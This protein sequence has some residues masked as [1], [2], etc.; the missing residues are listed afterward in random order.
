MFP[1][2]LT[3]FSAAPFL[4]TALGVVGFFIAINARERL[5]RLEWMVQDLERSQRI[6]REAIM[7]G[8]AP[9]ATGTTPPSASTVETAPHPDRESIAPERADVP[10]P[11]P[12]GPPAAEPVSQPVS[13]AAT[14]PAQPTS[15]EERIGTRWVVYVGGLALA[16][17]GLL[18]ARFAIEQGFFGPAMRI[19]TGLALAVALI[20]FGEKLRRRDAATGDAT[21]TPAVLTAAGT[22]TAFGVIYAAHALYGFIGPAF[23]L[24]ALGATALA[25]LLAAL[26]HGPAIAGLGLIGALGAPLLVHSSH[27]NPWPLAIYLAIVVG[28]AYALARLR[29]WGWLAIS[30]TVGAALWG[31]V[32]GIGYPQVHAAAQ[33]HFAFHTALAAW[34]YAL[35]RRALFA[36][37]DLCRKIANLVP[38][39]F[40]LFAALQ[41]GD[42][43]ARGG[44]DA[45]WSLCVAIIIGALAFAGASRPTFAPGLLLAAGAVVVELLILWPRVWGAGGADGLSRPGWFHAFAVIGSGAVAALSGRALWRTEDLSRRAATLLASAAALTPLLALWVTRELSLDYGAIETPFT[46]ALWTG[47]AL[48][49]ASGYSAFAWA[50]RRRQPPAP[51]D[52]LSLGLMASAGF[53][54]LALG[55]DFA[56]ESGALT[57]ALALS[58]LGAALVESRLD[59]SAL[60][61]AVAA[62][63]L[64]IAARLAWDPRIV[65]DDLGATPILNWLLFGYGVPAGS[66]GFAARLLGRAKQ[67]GATRIAQT[68][69]VVFSALLVYFEIRHAMTGGDMTG[70]RASLSEFGL[71]AIASFGFSHALLRL[72]AN[73]T[74]PVFG[75]FSRAFAIGASAGSAF[76]LLVAKNPY[77]DAVP[78]EGGAFLNALLLGYP[79]PA[80]AAA[81]LANT[82]ET[83]PSWFLRM[84]RLTALALT[85]AYVTLETRRLFQGAMIG[86]QAG[87][88]SVEIYAYSAVW[89]ALGVALLGFGLLRGSL[90]SRVASA[91][92]VLLAVLKVFCYDL[93]ALE[94]AARAFSFIC[95]GAVLIGIGL[96][97]QKLVFRPS[98]EATSRDADG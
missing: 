21:P 65:G 94:G 84:T 53:A 77:L 24:V 4:L 86:W 6:L 48:M 25:A 23:A 75:A 1:D 2:V 37:F 74:R 42:F 61:K 67:D 55:L 7:A 29:Q 60:R 71:Y 70:L 44:I 88:G 81:L 69:A 5:Q 18:L 10:P 46:K 38:A 35:D 30:A 66:F 12:P 40:A 91:G 3:L 98:A 19:A 90:E 20:V 49:V 34:L 95:L 27:P 28:A 15:L 16:L 56:L 57:V 78:V 54:A 73:G 31:G 8:V 14:A 87:A 39:L 58:A 36:N 68:L 72:D 64:V 9:P 22:T 96:V 85:F 62:M 89:L 50:L 80:A 47:A 45:F 17:G 43:A 11:P 13:I 79:L 82:I 52:R 26:L 33:L 92:V 63:G 59:I 41:F 51:S 32:M 93:G 83:R 76:G 97:Y